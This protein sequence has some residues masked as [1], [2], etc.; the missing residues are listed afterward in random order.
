M[1]T[2]HLQSFMVPLRCS[3]Q[4]GKD[5]PYI[6][7][8]ASSGPFVLTDRDR[9]HVAPMRR[10]WRADGKTRATSHRLLLLAAYGEMKPQADEDDD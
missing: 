6:G 5:N 2:E 9:M 7:S 3:R 4:R 10:A 8:V 1:E